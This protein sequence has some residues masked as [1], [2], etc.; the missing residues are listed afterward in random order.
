METK[1][2]DLSR[3][4]LSALRQIQAGDL[5]GKTDI[6]PQ[7]RFEAMDSAFGQCGVGWKFEIVKLWDYPTADG[8]ILCFAQINL[9]TAIGDDWSSPIP[10]IGGNTLVDM[11]KG[12]NQGD[13]KRAKPNDEG[14]KMAITDALGTAMK[15]IGVAADIYRGN[16]DGSKYREDSAPK[17]KQADTPEIVALKQALIDYINAGAFDHPENV[18]VV[19]KAGNIQKMR[20]ALAVA[21]KKEEAKK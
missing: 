17:Q 16:F 1:Y 15:V 2:K 5:K 11:V 7:W 18:E 6:N 9:Y 21:K 20:E 19:M 13:P 14:Y 12:Y 8:T 10:G 4:P 3:P